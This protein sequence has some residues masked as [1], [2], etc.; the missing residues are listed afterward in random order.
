M[1]PHNKSERKRESK[2][3][4]PKSYTSKTKQTPS[5]TAPRRTEAEIPC[6]EAP[7]IVSS[8]DSKVPC[9]YSQIS[10]TA[11]YQRNSLELDDSLGILSPG[12]MKDFTLSSMTQSFAS[13]TSLPR[14][15]SCEDLDSSADRTVTE[16][17]DY[18]VASRF[19]KFPLN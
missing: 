18:Q 10:S 6:R 7:D 11:V 5:R 19:P 8:C 16:E 3:R 14:D 17:F 4:P 15:I 9:I 2:L 12:D 1:D 13:V